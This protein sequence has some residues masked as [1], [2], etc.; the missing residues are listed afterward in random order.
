MN[1]AKLSLSRLNILLSLLL[2]TIVG[3]QAPTSQPQSLAPEVRSDTELVLNNA[4]LEQSN[5]EE[6]TVWKIRA[7]NIVYSEDKQ[8][9]TLSQ[10]VGNLW[11]NDTIILKIS[12]QQGEVRDNGNLILLNQEIIASDPRNNSVINSDAVEWRPQENRMLIK[13]PLVGTHPN[14]RVTADSGIYFTDREQLA[15][16]GQV[17]ATTNQPA[18][19]LTSDRLEWNIAQEQIN[20]P[21][22]LQLVRYDKNQ[23]V[24]EKLIS[25]R[26]TVNLL[27]Q[28]A[29]LNQNVEL[30]TLDPQLQV[31]TELFI[32]NYQQRSG[33]TDRP[34]QI[35]DRDRQI[36]LTGN[37]GSIN[38]PQQ[39]ATLKAGVKGVNP[40][41]AS[42]LY[43]RQLTW[44]MAGSE[45]EATGNVI[46]EQTDP[47]ARLTGDKAVGN[48]SNNNIV[49]TGNEQQVETVIDN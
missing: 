33:N 11:Q 19:Q 28:T 9:A 46:Y 41:Q 14:L 23:T 20:S 36:S 32:W 2:F 18:L 13:E 12:A 22:A 7:D 37:Q 8:T 1:P 26:A 39:L 35:L 45:V 6:N 34:I 43:A 40:Q 24:T 44:K 49:V 42:E 4:I 21:G 38:L 10:V 30:I 31:A 48:F 17:I 15:I 27:D 5:Q 29:T 25:D 3:C 47:Q 16:E